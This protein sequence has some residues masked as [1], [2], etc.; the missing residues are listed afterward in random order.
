VEGD[1]LIILENNFWG[2]KWL[3]ESILKK[4]KEKEKRKKKEPKENWRSKLSGF[5]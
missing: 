1:K 3:R 4:E 5:N 2:K